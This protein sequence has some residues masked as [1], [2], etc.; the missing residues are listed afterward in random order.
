MGAELET[1]FE[2]ELN[3]KLTVPISSTP[4]TNSPIRVSR[5]V[6]VFHGS[7]YHTRQIVTFDPEQDELT[8][9]HA[10]VKMQMTY[11]KVGS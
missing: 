2:R 1:E 7:D 5:H 3:E 8:L 10:G 6:R 11:E 9:E 4:V